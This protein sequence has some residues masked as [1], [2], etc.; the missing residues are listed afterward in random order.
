M[1]STSSERDL[2]IVVIANKRLHCVS[3]RLI[4]PLVSYCY[5]LAEYFPVSEK[6]N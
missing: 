4:A 1:I 2:L 5:S 6:S 3:L